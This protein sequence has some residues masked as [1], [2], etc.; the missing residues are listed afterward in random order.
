MLLK[1]GKT[2]GLISLGIPEYHARKKKNGFMDYGPKSEGRHKN[3]KYGNA[4]PG[5]HIETFQCFTQK[6]LNLYKL[7]Q[8]GNVWNL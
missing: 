7:I 5:N 4:K 2:N 6:E 8:L 3:Y 1:I